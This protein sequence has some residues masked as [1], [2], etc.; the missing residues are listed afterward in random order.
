MNDAYNNVIKN[1]FGED[2][3]LDDLV[4]SPIVALKANKLDLKSRGIIIK[5][6]EFFNSL[7]GRVLSLEDERVR[8]IHDDNN[9]GIYPRINSEKKAP[10]CYINKEIDTSSCFYLGLDN[11]VFFYKNNQRSVLN[12]FSKKNIEKT[13]GD[14]VIF[15]DKLSLSSAYVASIFDDQGMMIWPRSLYD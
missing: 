12:F 10:L 1:R 13:N 5:H 11:S 6:I 7:G 14:K 9:K 15:Y 8:F 2:L 4:A 3:K